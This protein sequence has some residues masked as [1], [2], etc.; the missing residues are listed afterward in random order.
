VGAATP[1]TPKFS[2]LYTSARHLDVE[3]CGCSLNPL[4]GIDREW[5]LRQEWAKDSSSLLSL[6]AGTTFAPFEY[7][8]ANKN[9]YIKKAALLIEAFNAMGVEIMTPS[10]ED[11]IFGQQQVA[12]W[13]QATRATWTSANLYDRG[14]HKPIFPAFAEHEFGADKVTVIGVS[15]CK[16][17][18]GAHPDRTVECRAAVPALKAVFKKLGN[19]T[20]LTVVMGHLSKQEVEDVRKQFP[21]VNMVLN[22]DDDDYQDESSQLGPSQLYANPFDR[23]RVVTRF[24]F[25]GSEPIRAFYSPS[26]SLRASSKVDDIKISLLE[27]ASKL[28]GH[29]SP[30]ERRDLLS[31]QAAAK[32]NLE[33]Q[34]TIS[35]ITPDKSMRFNSETGMLSQ[36][37]TDPSNPMAKLLDRFRKET[38]DLA[39]QQASE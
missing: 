37:Y 31:Q 20:D 9:Y 26:Y 33:I 16:V 6:S 35:N 39:I 8:A 10:Y 19:R 24:D 13:R 3:P 1:V 17:E 27:I 5:K 4:G 23:G 14:T 38:H 30:K 22:S 36:E 12:T 28:K 7:R 29:V 32:Q 11:F 15:G 18:S 34:Q 2:I 25:I 21:Q